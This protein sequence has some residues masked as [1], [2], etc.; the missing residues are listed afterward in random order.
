MFFSLNAHYDTY[1]RGFRLGDFMD[2]PARQFH[3]RASHR[4]T[5]TI[6]ERTIKHILQSKVDTSELILP[7]LPEQTRPTIVKTLNKNHPTAMHSSRAT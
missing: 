4:L 6:L 3:S 2:I 7:Q 5:A 1:Y